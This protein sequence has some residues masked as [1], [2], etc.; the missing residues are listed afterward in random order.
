V[1]VPSRLKVVTTFPFSAESQQLLK[2]AAAPEAV[3]MTT[4]DELSAHLSD[5]EIVCSY[6]IPPDWRTLAPKLQWLQFPG[7]GVDSLA[8]TGMLDADSG[9][10]VT[11][12]AGIHAETISEYV[13]GSMLMFNWNWPQMMRLQDE[14]VWAR[15]ATW[16]HLGGRELAG[17]TLGIIGLGHIGRRIAQLGHAF[18]MRVL[19][20]RRSINASGEQL[21]DVDQYFQSEQ[22]HEFLPQCDYIVISVPLTQETEKLIGKA[23]LRIM[24]R[25]AYLVNIARGRVVD[26]Q[27]LIQ[28]LHDGWIAG[29]GLDV[30]EVEPLPSDSPLYSMPN[31][32]LTPH[33]SGN[34]V[35]YDARLA[36]LFADNLRR[37]RSGQQ[38]QNRYEPSRGY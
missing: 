12:A 3:V 27:A 25:N 16:Y 21:Q 4:A 15:S 30:T 19:G 23:E 33:I 14:H 35:H 17:Q 32:I 20:V 7:A 24:R 13:F 5:A 36:A 6:S 9:V 34:S 22:L 38:L 28:A 18:G 26:E 8:K 1:I 29:A 37:Y 31:V 10:I 2:E 11:T